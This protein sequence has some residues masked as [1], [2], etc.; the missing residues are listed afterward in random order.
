[1]PREPL[2]NGPCSR[3]EVFLGLSPAKT[4]LPPSS[5]IPGTMAD[6]RPDRFS[7]R[8]IRS[9]RESLPLV[10]GLGQIAQ[11]FSGHIE[12][13]LAQEQ[14]PW[15][16]VSLNDRNHRLCRANRIAG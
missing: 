4:G 13:D 14:I 1:M 9:H 12:S 8:E 16:L 10:D 2:K 11:L 6:K 3:Q 15:R 5:P 7:V